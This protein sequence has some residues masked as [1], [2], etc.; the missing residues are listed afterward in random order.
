MSG[1]SVYYAL[2]EFEGDYGIDVLS[3]KK[4][5]VDA[6]ISRLEFGH[7]RLL[8]KGFT[9][10]DSSQFRS[11]N[12]A[13][14]TLLT[15]EKDGFE[16]DKSISSIANHQYSYFFSW[17]KGVW[18]CHDTC[19]MEG[20]VPWTHI[21]LWQCGKSVRNSLTLNTHLDSLNTLLLLKKKMIIRKA[22]PCKF[23]I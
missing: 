12:S 1:E 6:I 4:R 23:S 8:H 11:T 7:G 21:K 19:E 15:A 3:H 9:G 22:S 16:V 5:I 14:R 10:E 17:K 13:L 2:Q 18:F 20:K